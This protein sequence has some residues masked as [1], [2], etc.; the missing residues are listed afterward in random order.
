LTTEKSH[1]PLTRCGVFSSARQATWPGQGAPLPVSDR[2]L[3]AFLVGLGIKHLRFD[4]PDNVRPKP[5]SYGEKAKPPVM[6]GGFAV[7]ASPFL[8]KKAA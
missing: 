2:K 4:T 5:T 3:Y 7:C 6:A 8:L 1:T